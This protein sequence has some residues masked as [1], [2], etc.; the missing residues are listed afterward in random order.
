MNSYYIY[1]PL[2]NYYENLFFVKKKNQC[3]W[4]L[5]KNDFNRIKPI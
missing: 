4:L 3:K 2:G 1:Y 5:K